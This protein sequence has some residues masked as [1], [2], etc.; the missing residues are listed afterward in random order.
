MAIYATIEDIEKVDRAMLLPEHI[1]RIMHMDPQA[2]R[3]Y[4]REEK[5]AGREPFPFPTTIYGKK[6]VV[7]FPKPEFSEWARNNRTDNA[8]T[9]NA[10]ALVKKAKGAK[11]HPVRRQT[12]PKAQQIR[13]ILT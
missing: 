2:I 10:P 3:V 6:G 11:C 8:A 1:A 12:A 7:R 4:A 13:Y 5:A 9:K